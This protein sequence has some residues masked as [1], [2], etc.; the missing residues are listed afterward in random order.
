MT[1]ANSGSHHYTKKGT[2]GAGAPVK[3]MGVRRCGEQLQGTGVLLNLCTG[4]GK[5]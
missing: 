3:K 1:R 4:M 2:K 5:R